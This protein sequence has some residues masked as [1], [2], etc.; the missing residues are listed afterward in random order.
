VKRNRVLVPLTCAECG[1]DTLPLICRFLEP[2]KTE[3]IILHV[4]EMPEEAE[5][6]QRAERIAREKEKR[7]ASVPTRM[8]PTHRTEEEP[9]HWSRV[10]VPESGISSARVTESKR[11]EMAAEYQ[12]II[13]ELK[14]VGYSASVL[15]RFGSDPARRIR[16]AAETEDVDLIAMATHGRSGLSRLLAGSVAESVVRE[17]TTPV[18]LAQIEEVKP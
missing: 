2:E 12:E 18:L 13:Q 7:A 10:G 17:G 9:E 5:V 8:Q 4:G 11:Q 1:E 14:D 6:I 16:R 15:I 3:L